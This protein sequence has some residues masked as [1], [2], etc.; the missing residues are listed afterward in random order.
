METPGP[1]HTLDAQMMNR[2]P[3]RSINSALSAMDW[4]ENPTALPAMMVCLF[5]D[6]G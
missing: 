1:S 4:W 3:A 6:P 5:S 2:R